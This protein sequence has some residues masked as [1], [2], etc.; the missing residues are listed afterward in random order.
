MSVI[1]MKQFHQVFFEESEEHLEEMEQLLLALD[2]ESPDAEHL[3]SIFRAAHSIKGGS[4]I[5]GFEMLARLTHVLE[6]L[7][8]KIRHQQLAINEAR[9]DIFLRTIDRSSPI[10]RGQFCVSARRAG[11]GVTANGAQGTWPY[12]CRV[13]RRRG[14]PPAQ[15]W[16]R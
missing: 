13:Y 3:N 6:S 4:G 2:L 9:V 15:I 7:L 10:A 5:F 12:S 16:W 14:R 1:D 8:D 11:L